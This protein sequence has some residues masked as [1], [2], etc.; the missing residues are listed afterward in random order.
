MFAGGTDNNAGECE[1]SYIVVRLTDAHVARPLAREAFY[2]SAP[3]VYC[4][5]MV[6]RCEGAMIPVRANV[7]LTCVSV[8]LSRAVLSPAHMGAT[9]QAAVV[10]VALCR[11][12]IIQLGALHCIACLPICSSAP[13]AVGFRGIRKPWRKPSELPDLWASR[14]AHSAAGGL[15]PLQGGRCARVVGYSHTAPVWD[16]SDPDSGLCF[17]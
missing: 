11:R 15:C 3:V 2:V 1:A 5:H 10:R 17:V 4:W 6:V 9:P 8:C 13:C 12:D 14:E 16:T 7:L